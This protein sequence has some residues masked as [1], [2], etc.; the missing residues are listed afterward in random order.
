LAPSLALSSA[1]VQF[2]SI[3]YASIPT[4]FAQSHLLTSLPATVHPLST[5]PRPPRTFTTYGAACP[6]IPQPREP[7]GGSL[8][9]EPAAHLYDEWS[10]LNLTIAVPKAVL[11]QPEGKKVPVM[12][13]VHG[14]GAREGAGH[15]DGM[16]HNA[17]LCA[18][19]VHDGMELIVVNV[20]KLFLPCNL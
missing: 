10:C 15:V 8:P 4:R 17:R 19:S 1:I 9:G 20:G 13:Y 18:L 12:V 2:R 7:Y 16:H 6:S 3:P 5:H 14:G 11:E